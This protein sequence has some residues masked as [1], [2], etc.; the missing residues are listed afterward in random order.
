ML[1]KICCS[2]VNVLRCYNVIS[3]LCKILN[4]ISNCCGTGSNCQSCCTALQCCDSLFKHILCR[5]GQTAI[6]ITCICQSE[7]SCCM[8]TV[9]EYVG[10][11]LVD[12]NCSCISNR[13]RLF[14]SYM[15]LKCFEFKLSVL[16]CNF[17][18]HNLIL[19]SVFLIFCCYIMYHGVFQTQKPYRAS[20]NVFCSF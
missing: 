5:V 11:C 9:A 16:S 4:C 13:I 14:L 18:T 17:F 10:R 2:T 19:F 12:W 7:T 3:L 20:T 6:D 8:I 15:K 1:Q